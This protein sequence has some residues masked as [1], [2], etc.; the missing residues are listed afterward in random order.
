[1][2]GHQYGAVVDNQVLLLVLP[3]MEITLVA[4]AAVAA[5]APPR[6]ALVRALAVL[7]LPVNASLQ[8]SLTNKT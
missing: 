1:L 8:N 4:L 5:V 3:R 7:V 6:M 2:A